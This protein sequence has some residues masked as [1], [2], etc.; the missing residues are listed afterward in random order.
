MKIFDGHNDILN[1]I[2]EMPDPLNSKAFLVSDPGQLDFPRALE[3]CVMG[4][5]FAVYTSNPPSV[6]SYKERMVFSD[7]GYR[8][9]LPP[10]LDYD[11]AHQSALQMIELL[12]KIQEDALGQFQVVTSPAELDFCIKNNIFAAVLHLEGAEPIQ[13]N[14]ENLPF[15]YEKGMRSLGITWSRPNKFG[16]GVPFAYPS[17]PDTGPGLTAEG[18][19]L[20]KSCNDLG[21]MIDLAHLNEK[22][23]WDV[24]DLS[25]SPLVSTHTAAGSLVPKSRNLTDEQ[26]KAVGD[27]NGLVGIIFS[28]N[29]LDGGKRPKDNAPISKIIEHICYVADLIGVD[30]VA[31]GSDFDGT[32]IPAELGDVSGYPKLVALLEGAGFTTQE[33]EMICSQNWIR[34]LKNTWKF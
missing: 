31:F 18:K 15:F 22:G 16:H 1:K 9:T 12:Y 34:V 30:H 21:V 5:F 32:E 26:L 27:S 11:Y 2:A 3:A 14:L 19:E 25:S 29:D 6:P 20:V 23:F 33:M 17:G 4:G 28:V 24:A 10:A 13:P 7:E 8:I